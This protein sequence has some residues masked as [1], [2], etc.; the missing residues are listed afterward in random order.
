MKAILVVL[1]VIC[2]TGSSLL[3]WKQITEEKRFNTDA[4]WAGILFIVGCFCVVA[5]PLLPGRTYHMG[6]NGLTEVVPMAQ[7]VQP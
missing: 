2:L 3:I 6:P 5:K 7:I 1:G 4:F